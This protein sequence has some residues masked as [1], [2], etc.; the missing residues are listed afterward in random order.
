MTTLILIMKR[1]GNLRVMK[2]VLSSEGFAV[3]SVS[4]PE[5]LK[6]ALTEAN[7]HCIGLVDVTG[8]GPSAWGMCES[9]H[10]CGMR[11][12][13]LSAPEQARI[14]AQTL[15]YGATTLIEKPVG[16]TALLQLLHSLANQGKTKNS[17]RCGGSTEWTTR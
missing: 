14:G 8:F 3:I 10:A 4:T 11:F 6:P 2:Q 5:E 13:V 15:E 17:I 16:K 9:L 7:E 12:I 1:P